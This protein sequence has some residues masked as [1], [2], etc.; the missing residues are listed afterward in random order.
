VD[1][2]YP[3]L[4]GTPFNL[5][6]EEWTP[7]CIPGF[8]PTIYGLQSCDVVTWHFGDGTP[9][10]SVTGVVGHQEK[11]L[12]TYAAAS[13][14]QATVTISNALG[15]EHTGGLVV[16]AS[17]PPTYVD[18]SPA[19]ITAPE[20]AGSITFT[21]VRS[22]N[23]T[24][25]A[26]VHYL[27]PA[28]WTGGPQN[29]GETISGD[30]TFNPGETT[31][32]IT[33]TVYDDH[34]YTVPVSDFVYA[35]ATDGT[36]FHV[37]SGKYTLTEVTPQPTATVAD[38]RVAEGTATQNTA[39]VVVTMSAPIAGTSVEIL[40]W[41]SDGTAKSPF[42]YG[43]DTICDIPQGA[44][45]C[46]LHFKIVNDD[47]PE[48]DET[49]TVKVSTIVSPAGPLFTR[50][51]ATV[52]IVND[53]AA[54]TPASTQIA[55][56]AHVSLKLD[57]GQAPA[58]PL[59]IPLQSS[60]PEVLEVPASVT[61]GA[62][63]STARVNAH[64]LQAGRSRVTASVP[65]TNTPSSLITVVDAVTIVADPSAITLRAGSDA[66]VSLSLQPPRAAA[67][68]VSLSS[69]SS[70][71]AS[72]PSSL[73]IPGDGKATLTIHALKSGVA[74]IWIVTP[75]G[76][77][78]P[79]DVTVVDGPAASVARIVPANASAAGGSNVM[80]VGEGL[81]AH[82]SVSFGSAPATAVTPVGSG[83]SVVVPAHPP[84]V[85]DVTVVCGSA[86][87]ALPNA[88]TFFVPRRR[89]AG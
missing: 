69:T 41:P 35:T 78:F 18:F 60:S 33:M 62:G 22:G 74:T 76:F 52:T 7:E 87:I 23:L 42:D 63:E 36:R 43:E 21:L 28:S 61:F 8:C 65:G 67:L 19:E 1:A 86:R 10:V 53:D 73:A 50:D 5:V 54:I 89:A 71:V 48:P 40:G 55:T 16:V 59:T 58:A 20:T 29:Q 81:D 51:T 14:Y 39:D 47:V 26:K 46:V 45:Q 88:F 85:V 38:A 11:I 17:D 31:K 68:N 83:L 32:T 84:G 24:T 27:H 2:E 6:L 9:D 80:I 72:A 15:T 82:C 57:I 44:T 56:G 30:L 13:T 34:L 49:F 3:S 64:A 79:V 25:T 66:T 12:H 75:E 70:E 4:A 37:D 77:T